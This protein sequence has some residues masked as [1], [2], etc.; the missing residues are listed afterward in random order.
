MKTLVSEMM[1]NLSNMMQDL[2]ATS[3]E[4]RCKG[5]LKTMVLNAS[6]DFANN[7]QS[8]F[9]LLAIASIVVVL[10]KRV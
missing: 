3:N 6:N 7:A 2:V 4:G 9:V 8:T 10:L 5:K 1:S